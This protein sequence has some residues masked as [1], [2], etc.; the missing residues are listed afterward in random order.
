MPADDPGP[1]W[2]MRSQIDG[3]SRSTN[4]LFLW[5]SPEM[6]RWKARACPGRRR[7]CAGIQLRDGIRGCTDELHHPG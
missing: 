4:T 5:A 1:L 6:E 3:F 2:S 7:V